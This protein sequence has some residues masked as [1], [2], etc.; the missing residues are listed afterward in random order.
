MVRLN[1]EFASKVKLLSKPEKT[2]LLAIKRR[3]RKVKESA[4]PK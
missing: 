2:F 4:L 3:L 1:A